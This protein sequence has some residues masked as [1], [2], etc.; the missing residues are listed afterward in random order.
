MASKRAKL[1]D[2]INYRMRVVLID[3]RHFTGQMLAFDKFMNVVL[4]D[5]E[6]FRITKR[7]AQA[8][9]Q[10]AARAGVPG[11]TPAVTESVEEK[12]TLGLVLLR[13]ENIISISVEAPPPSE[14]GPRLGTIQPG[15]GVARAV[16]R[17][18]GGFVPGMGF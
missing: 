3:G 7:S 6:E 11:S 12:R 16:G 8:R 10:A 14:E 9:R 5:C 15:M 4:A 13:G 18:L 17:G 1:A 2:L